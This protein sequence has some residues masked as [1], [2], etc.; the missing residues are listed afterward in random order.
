M[1]GSNLLD[2]CNYQYIDGTKFDE[3]TYDL[4]TKFPPGLDPIE[5]G[6]L[7]ATRAHLEKVSGNRN[8]CFI[9]YAW[10]NDDVV[11]AIDAWLMRKR[12][13][14]KLDKCD[15]FAGSHI[16]DEIIRVMKDC[17]TVLIFRSKDS[18]DKPWP[19]FERE[20]ATD[21][22]IQAKREKRNHFGL[23]T[24]LLMI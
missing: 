10:A 4:L 6:A 16:R 17:D 20:L 3:A 24:L 21:L 22:Q 9:S 12:I 11:L 23:F 1:C 5:V 2:T 8:L 19:D 13:I 14:T 15:F 7:Y 18:V